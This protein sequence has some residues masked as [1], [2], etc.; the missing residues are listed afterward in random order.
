MATRWEYN[1]K[2]RNEL[3][4]EGP[5]LGNFDDF[6]SGR[7]YRPMFGCGDS[8]CLVAVNGTSLGRG[9]LILDVP[10]PHTIREGLREIQ[11]FP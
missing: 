8:C 11:P 1:W 7:G 3:D 9:C 6:G 5:L 4:W 10:E 2:E